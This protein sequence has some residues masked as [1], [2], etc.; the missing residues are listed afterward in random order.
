MPIATNK[1]RMAKILRRLEKA[2]PQAKVALAHQNPFELLVATILSAQCTDARVNQVT[3]KLFS[4]Y[5]T[6][7]DFVKMSSVALEAIIRSTGFYKNK[8]KSIMGAAQKIVERFC[9][10]VPSTMEALLTLPGVGR[11][12][13][14]VVLGHAFGVP[15]V[16]VDTHVR[17]VAN[18]LGLTQSQN[19][20]HIEGD[21][22]LLMPKSKWIDGG[23]R[24][25]LHGRHVCRARTPL[26]RGCTLFNLCPNEEEK[27]KAENRP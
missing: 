14:N 7:S 4:L 19:P 2:I 23:S 27:Q 20:D 11:K 1:A 16:V 10:E 8:A 13:A 12:T 18:R 5:K 6:P 21:L 3:P 17:R 25:L 22:G 24:L 9:G 26:C 15:G